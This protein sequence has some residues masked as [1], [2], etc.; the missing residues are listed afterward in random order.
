V[1]LLRLRLPDV[2][3]L[4][5][6]VRYDARGWFKECFRNDMLQGIV[7]GIKP[8]VQDN[9]SCSAKGVLR[10]LHWQCAPHAQGKLVQVLSGATYTV[11]VDVRPA[12]A[13]YTHWVGIYL[14]AQQHQALWIPEGFAHGFLVLHDQTCVFYKTTDY[15]DPACNRVVSWKSP[16]LGIQ[17][18]NLDVPLILSEQDR[19]APDA[20]P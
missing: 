6:A 13:T 12:S 4:R 9:I 1:S 19:L 14:H 3:L 20:L 16:Q 10:G 5:Q 11:A 2:L 7:S 15:F 17:W 8:F 18:P